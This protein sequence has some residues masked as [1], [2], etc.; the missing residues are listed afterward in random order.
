MKK[1]ANQSKAFMPVFVSIH[2]K[3]PGC[4]TIKGIRKSGHLYGDLRF[5]APKGGTL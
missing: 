3:R 4:H 5:G 2:A 1:G